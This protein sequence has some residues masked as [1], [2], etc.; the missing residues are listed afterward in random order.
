MKDR[1]AF[2]PFLPILAQFT[3]SAEKERVFNKPL[4]TLQNSPLKIPR[5][6]I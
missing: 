4:K 2:L 6:R 3:I 1:P 5:K